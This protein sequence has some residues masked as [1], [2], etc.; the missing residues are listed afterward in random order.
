[1]TGP[2]IHHIGIASI[3]EE[4][5]R[6]LRSA[7]TDDGSGVVFTPGPVGVSLTHD[8]KQT[9]LEQTEKNLLRV[10]PLNQPLEKDFKEACFDVMCYR[11][12]HEPSSSRAEFISSVQS[13]HG[14]L[15]SADQAMQTIKAS[16]WHSDN[17]GSSIVFHRTALSTYLIQK[18]IGRMD[19]L[20]VHDFLHR[21]GDPQ[22]RQFLD[23]YGIFCE[24]DMLQTLPSKGERASL[25][26]YAAGFDNLPDER[27]D[28]LRRQGVLLAID[29]RQVE[30]EVGKE[31]FVVLLQGWSDGKG[32]REK[33]SWE[34][35]LPCLPSRGVYEV[36]LIE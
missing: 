9:L 12:P 17:G 21:E 28:E 26:E 36:G 34:V 29:L 31:P 24:S 27:V 19:P 33:E 23:D 10:A 2:G 3:R 32:V 30:R 13:N 20:S 18:H 4:A 35:V 5:A 16:G 14:L 7:T 8:E 6:V 15:L 11:D 25:Y 1:M 22:E